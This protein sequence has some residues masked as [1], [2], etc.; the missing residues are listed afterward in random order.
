[1]VLGFGQCCPFLTWHHAATIGSR[2]FIPCWTYHWCTWKGSVG[3][4]FLMHP[5]RMLFGRYRPGAIF[6]AM[7]HRSR[8]RTHFDSL[9]LHTRFVASYCTH[10]IPQRSRFAIGS[11]T[12]FRIT[13]SLHVHT[14]NPCEVS[15]IGFR[16]AGIH[17]DTVK[18]HS[19]GVYSLD[20][21]MISHNSTTP[22]TCKNPADRATSFIERSDVRLAPSKLI[23]AVPRTHRATQH[24]EAGARSLFDPGQQSSHQGGCHS[25]RAFAEYRH[26]LLYT[27]ARVPAT[28][29]TWISKR[30]LSG[31]LQPPRE[32]MPAQLRDPRPS[33]TRPVMIE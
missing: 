8:D 16:D 33:K 6:P 2:C 11:E 5:M 9:Q 24:D 4:L 32:A 19:T 15:S 10:V 20:A 21:F 18:H 17:L 1:M 7:F 27:L 23:A 31:Q 14:D 12:T 13:S 3:T 26:P 28:S 29:S 30:C 25:T 22:T